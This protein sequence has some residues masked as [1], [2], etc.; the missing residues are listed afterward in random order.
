MCAEVLLEG[1][2]E[3]LDFPR[4]PGC[5]LCATCRDSGME[6]P[7][8]PSVSGRTAEENPPSEATLPWFPS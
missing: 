6:W 2:L 1:L 8:S 7:A 4:N 3:T 5:W